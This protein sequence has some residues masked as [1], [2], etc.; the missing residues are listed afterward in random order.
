MPTL[1]G[2]GS[3]DI[4]ARKEMLMNFKFTIEDIDN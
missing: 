3:D 1:V 4:K 2:K